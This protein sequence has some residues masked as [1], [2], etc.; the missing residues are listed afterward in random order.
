[1]SGI[2]SRKYRHEYKYIIDSV[3][4]AILEMRAAGLLQRDRHAGHA[5]T[6]LIKSLYFDDYEDSCFWEKED[7]Y[8][9]RSKFRIRY[10][11][12]DSNYL[13][14]EKKS[15][16]NGM[17]CKESVCI[18]KEMCREFMKG[19]IPQVEENMS[20]KMKELFTEMRIRKLQPKV[21]V[22]YERAPYVCSMGNVRVTF[23]R[24]LSSSNDISHFLD[25]DLIVRPVMQ[26]GESLMEI[27]W[28]EVLPEYISTQLSLDSLQWNSFSK[29]CLCRKYN[30]YG[31]LSV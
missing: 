27:K 31:G 2:M 21:I 3:E 7:G 10:Y 11:N 29:Y 15:K 6:Y 9:E 16:K 26:R 13:R 25:R 28:D 18:T 19:G 24:S 23:D 17:C 4:A 22:I 5:G 12:N 20:E 8:N 1:M 30:C 14:L